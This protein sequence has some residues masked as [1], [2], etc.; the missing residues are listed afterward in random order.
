MN[1]KNQLIDMI[2]DGIVIGRMGIHHN[3]HSS[4]VWD[5]DSPKSYSVTHT[6]KINDRDMLFVIN[7][8]EFCTSD[9]ETTS[10]QSATVQAEQHLIEI[11]F[12]YP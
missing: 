3:T 12:N 5:T 9:I 2:N 6:Q 11:V 7:G 4:P 1:F 8:V 10:S